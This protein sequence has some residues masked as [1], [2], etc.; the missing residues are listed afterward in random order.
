MTKEELEK[1]WGWID[2][3]F[4]ETEIPGWTG[5]SRNVVQSEFDVVKYDLKRQFLKDLL[6]ESS[7]HS[8]VEREIDKYI[9]EHF[10]GSK[11]IGFLTNRRHD[12]PN[13]YDIALTARHFYNFG[14]QSKVELSSDVDEA[15]E[16][17]ANKE[18]PDEASCG[19]WGTG[20][21][22]PPVDMEYPREVAKDSFK[23]GAE[24][25]AG[26][27]TTKETVVFRDEDDGLFVEAFVKEPFK[28]ADKVIVQIRKIE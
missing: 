25:M 27:G 17:Y 7:L 15:A 5:E 14:K 28:M 20:D 3:H 8:D 26:Q 9:S 21:Y 6:Q 23:A 11:S 2:T 10:Y 24:W 4:H 16:E 12:Y 13:D 22:E 1:V 19:Q 18:Y